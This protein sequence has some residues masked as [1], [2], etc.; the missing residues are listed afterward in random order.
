[1]SE[2]T[3]LS[4]YVCPAIIVLSRISGLF[5]FAPV[6]SSPMI[7]GQMKAMLSLTLTAAIY[8]ACIPTLT[9]QGMIPLTMNIW[10]IIPIVFFELLIGVTIGLIAFI[11]IIAIQLGGLSVGQQMGLAMA[12]E[13][14]PTSDIE[15]NV[16]G[17]ILF[18]LS[19]LAFIGLG[20]IEVMVGTILHSFNTVPVGAFRADNDLLHLCTALITSSFELAMQIGAPVIGLILLQT[21]ALGFIAKTAPAFN[22]LSLGFPMR[23]ILGIGMI[24]ICVYMIYDLMECEMSNALDLMWLYFDT[25]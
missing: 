22:I 12:R 21:F 1:M 11:P 18:Y 9:A 20:G 14:D 19:L 6:L 8:P 2:L 24:T 7:P 17:Q 16:V 25:F 5:F 13:I 4:A 23:V 15:G 10:Y 3:T